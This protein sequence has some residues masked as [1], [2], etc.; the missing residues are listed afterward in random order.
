MKKK[1][2]L[3][4][5]VL[6]PFLAL[7]CA[8]AFAYPYLQLDI[9]GGTYDTGTETI[10]APSQQFT[11]LALQTPNDHT[12]PDRDTTFYISMALV[13]K[14][15]PS[16]AGDLGT[17]VFAGET[18]ACTADMVYGTAPL[19]SALSMQGWDAQDLAKHGIFETYFD[20]YEFRFRN[21]TIPSYNTQDRAISGDPIPTGSGDTLVKRF[22]VDTSNLNPAYVVHFDLYSTVVKDVANGDSV[23]DIDVDDFCPFSHDAESNHIPDPAAVFLLGSACLVGLGGLRRKF[24]M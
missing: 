20:E 13:P 10:I 3:S 15:D 9:D 11:L 2:F 24:H 14:V 17:I 8:P 22:D 16:G 6:V 4:L 5:L 12:E 18:I 21:G 1:T 7:W 19:E 23:R